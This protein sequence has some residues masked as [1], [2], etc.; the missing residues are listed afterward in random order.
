MDILS[1]RYQTSRCGPRNLWKLLW[2]FSRNISPNLFLFSWRVLQIFQK[3]LCV[4]QL[5]LW[6]QLLTMLL[7]LIYDAIL[8]EQIALYVKFTRILFRIITGL[9][10]NSFRTKLYDELGLDLLKTRRKVHELILFY[11][12][13]NVYSLKHL[14]DLI[15]PYRP[16]NHS[17]NL[18]TNDIQFNIPHN[19]TTSYMDT[20]HQLLNSGITYLAISEMLL[21]YLHSRIF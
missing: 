15:E 6:F 7:N 10:C 1:G 20:L 16:W 9:R 13:I 21:G 2:D 3:A 8:L 5:D 12:F 18:K 14:Y 11:R 17:Y 19:R 4:I